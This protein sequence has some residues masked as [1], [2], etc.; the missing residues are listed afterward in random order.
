MNEAQKQKI[1][2][3]WTS[4]NFSGAFLGIYSFARALK[5]AGLHYTLSQV[6]SALK[7]HQNYLIHQIGVLRFDRRKYKVDGWLQFFQAD[8]M[9]MPLKSPYGQKKLIRILVVID[10]NSLFIWT[11]IVPGAK[12]DQCKTAF[13]SIFKLLGDQRPECIQTDKG[14]GKFTPIVR[15]N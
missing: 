6:R 15:L 8:T 5:R 9:V 3:Y 2:S 4:P 12:A 14:T 11:R 1:L 7:S 10:L 13:I